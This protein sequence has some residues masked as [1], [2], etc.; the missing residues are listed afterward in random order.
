MCG[1]FGY[2][3]KD[4]LN[5][6]AIL[7]SM[8]RRGPDAK[9]KMS[10]PQERG[11][12]GKRC[13]LLHRRLSIIDLSSSASQPML[14]RSGQYSIV[15]NGMIY[16]YRELRAKLESLNYEFSTQSDTEVLL[17]SY[18]EWREGMLYK[19]R[20]MFA[21]C[22]YDNKEQ[23]LFLVRD[24]FGQKPLYY[25]E[26]NDTFCF[27]S[28]IS[29]LFASGIKSRFALSQHAIRYYLALGSFFAPNT[30]LKGVK[31]LLPGHY[32]TYQN[33]NI[34]LTK[35]FDLNQLISDSA[36]SKENIRR[37]LRTLMF[38]CV[39]KHMHSDV[40][41][42]VFLSGGID[43]SII[44]GIASK[45]SNER[46]K[47]FTIGFK[48]SKSLQDETTIA[49]KT[50][51]HINSVHEN[52]FLD[53]EDFDSSF[54][55]FINAIDQPSV[56]GLNTYFISKAVSDRI[57]VIL[58]GI[59]GDEMY[60]GYPIF[61]QVNELQNLSFIDKFVSKLPRKLLNHIG[62][63]YLNYVDYSLFDIL[64]D[65]RLLGELSNKYRIE[66]KE[67]IVRNEMVLKTIS[68]FEI[69]GYMSNVLLRD[70]D[71]VT[72]FHSIECRAPFVDKEVFKFAMSVPDKYKIDRQ[73]N[74][75]LLVNTFSDLLIK[76]TYGLPKRGFILPISKWIK[77]Y[78]CTEKNNIIKRTAINFNVFPY[79]CPLNQKPHKFNVNLVNKNYKW[80]V[81]MSWIEKNKN[82]LST[83]D[84]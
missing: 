49:S 2:I 21:F 57:K 71:A 52:I 36:D 16:N 40:P 56:D 60:A 6:E 4:S 19:L 5:D 64:M 22:I 69:S 74:K 13:T 20:G 32:L 76:E 84:C 79:E 18:I 78:L 24:H 28:T 55:E 82:Y 83:M 26:S 25:Y 68:I 41:I 17:Y 54:D 58:S 10:F 38:D 43:S 59:G 63:S 37:N 42:G 80:V 47:T 15:Y 29:A 9:G 8:A 48:Q 75:A 51:K 33:E 46:I 50:A 1:I 35:Y 7:G 73:I 65:K 72:M 31:S 62:K 61:H 34:R 27:S 12:K 39:E 67:N 14:D 23:R 11:N 77:N 3:S 70:T 44:A 81:L 66:L 53:Q 30:I 45:V